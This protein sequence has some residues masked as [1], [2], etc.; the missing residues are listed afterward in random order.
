MIACLGG[1]REKFPKVKDMLYHLE[2]DRCTSGGASPDDLL[3]V[4]M[5]RKAHAQ[6]D[7]RVNSDTSL[8][9]LTCPACRQFECMRVSTLLDHIEVGDCFAS[10]FDTR[11]KDG[12]WRLLTA[13]RQAM[14]KPSRK[15]Y[16]INV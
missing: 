14:G 13:I 12:I 1:C 10:Q 2:E 11:N 8:M 6:A 3:R 9:A 16:G 15:I 5:S 7:W 4:A